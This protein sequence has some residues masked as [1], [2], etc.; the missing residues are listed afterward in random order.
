MPTTK[1]NTIFSAVSSAIADRLSQR[2][3]LCP[4]PDRVR[5][6]GKTC[7]VT[8]ANS[9]LGKAVAID[10]AKRGGRVLMACRSGHPEAGEE[11]KRH[12]GSEN[13]EMLKVDL[14]DLESV[15]ALCDGLRRDIVRLDIVVLNAGVMPRTAQRSAQGYELMFAVHFLANRLLIDR[16]LADGTIRPG[17]RSGEIPRIVFV[18]SEQHRSAGPIDFDRFGAFSD[19]GLTDGLKHYGSSKLHLCTFAQE[20]SRRL[21]PDGEVRVAVT[22]LCPGPVN[23][24]LAREAPTLLKPLLYPVMRFFFAAPEKAAAPVTYA[25][26]AEEMGRR[27]GAYLHLMQ[28]KHPSALAMDEAAGTRLW[29]A[30]G[31]LLAAHERSPRSTT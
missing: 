31:A 20:L 8:G 21:K 17:P 15:H 2:K 6:D 11:V 12:S 29:E 14:A 24:N 28:E 19:Y 5:I 27:S 16:L 3:T 25:C 23:S 26:C 10:L 13:V 4:V 9:G 22:S 1:R 7:L 18:V 30:S